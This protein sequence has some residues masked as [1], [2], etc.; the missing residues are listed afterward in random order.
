MPTHSADTIHAANTKGCVGPYRGI[1]LVLMVICLL[2]GVSSPARERTRI[3]IARDTVFT[4]DFIIPA[5]TTCTIEP[6]VEI[7]FDGMYQCRVEGLLLAHGRA[8]RPILFSAKD[9]P[10][11]SNAHPQWKGLCIRGE[12]AHAAL[13]HCTIE[14]AKKN[15]VYNCSPVFS[16]CRF[17]NNHFALYCAKNASAHITRCRIEENAYGL[18]SDNAAPVAYDNHIL[19]NS[20]GISIRME[21]RIVAGRNI[22]ARNDTNRIKDTW[23]GGASHPLPAMQQLWESIEE[24][25]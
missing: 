11:G 15:I 14:G 24:V 25:K 9:R 7:R 13:S 2:A 21:G 23:L 12:A 20:V 19:N 8:E 6:G 18:V 16:D 17:S 5:Y 10:V 1:S 22:I 4:A 3:S